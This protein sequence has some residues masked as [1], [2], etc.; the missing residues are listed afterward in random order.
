[1]Q[2]RLLKRQRGFTLIEL[3]VV[4]AIIAILIAL[5]LPAV[6]QAREAARRTQ[7][8]NNLKQLALAC[9][10]YHDKFNQ[11]PLNFD[12]AWR[13]RGGRNPGGF[14]WITM[15]LPDLDQKPIYDR[16]NW[17]DYSDSGGNGANSNKPLRKLV[18]TALLCPSNPQG[19][20]RNRQNTG[21]QHGNSAWHGDARSDAGGT[22]YVGNMGMMWGGWKD[23]GAVPDFPSP[24]NL[25]N[26]GGGMGAP[27][28]W[29]N[30]DWIED[31]PRINGIF[32]Y[33]G[34]TRIRDCTDGTSSTV[35]LF[36][37]MHW[38]GGRNETQQHRHDKNV[39]WDSAWMSPLGAINTMRNPINNTKFNWLQGVGDVRCHGMSSMHPGGAQAA[40]TD[41][42][43]RMISENIDNIIRYAIAVRN[44]NIPAGDSF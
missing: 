23:C 19:G 9:H 17:N 26:K 36:E 33:K 40:L 42:S 44:D 31:Q 8:K 39:T 30:G 11:F 25:F 24:G 16:I 37:D 34:S 20:L 43:V 28:P 5:L 27:T 6:Q 32:K 13:N 2:T 38:R 21:Y 12:P 35:M 7:C 1:M 18:L 3:L 4:I 22:D 10:N 41:G 15:C 14:S 29:V